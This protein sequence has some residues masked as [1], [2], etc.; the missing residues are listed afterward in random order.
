M[1]K[2]K[3]RGV[4]GHTCNQL[5]SSFRAMIFPVADDRM[6]QRRELR[7][8]LILQAGFQLDPNQSCIG[9]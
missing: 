4:K 1:D 9:E 5:F 2:L 6:S 7:A 3:I 8:D